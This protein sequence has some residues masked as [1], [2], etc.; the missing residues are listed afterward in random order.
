[1]VQ[2]S[3]STVHLDSLVFN[4]KFTDFIR[5]TKENNW[6]LTCLVLGKLGPVL[7]WKIWLSWK[8]CARDFT[9]HKTL[10]SELM[11]K[12][13]WDTSHKILNL[14]HIWN[15]YLRMQKIPMQFFL[16]VQAYWSMSLKIGCL[17]SYVFKFVIFSHFILFLEFFFFFFFTSVFYCYCYC[18]K[19]GIKC[20]ESLVWTG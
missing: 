14:C 9:I 18:L 17:C 15:T 4:V 1:M 8:H 3:F 12:T 2:N 5:E 7:T 13:P 6:K 10:L 19:A 16:L 20:K 11:L